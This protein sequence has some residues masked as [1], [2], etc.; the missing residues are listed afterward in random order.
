MQSL[1]TWERN[2]ALVSQVHP[3]KPGADLLLH[4]ARKWQPNVCDTSDVPCGSG[5]WV[6]R[7][8]VGSECGRTVVVPILPEH[9]GEGV[10]RL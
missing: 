6:W 2:N 9:D 1:T 5:W 3:D 7:S 4:R 10:D 8:C